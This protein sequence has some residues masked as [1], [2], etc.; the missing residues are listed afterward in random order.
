MSQKL[1]TCLEYLHHYKQPNHQ[2]FLNAQP[3]H[4]IDV[5]FNEKF[6]MHFQYKILTTSLPGMKPLLERVN[7]LGYKHRRRFAS[8]EIE[9]SFL[10]Q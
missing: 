9:D 8:M 2:P 7:L 3:A 5:Y 4:N 10:Q 1:E 6:N